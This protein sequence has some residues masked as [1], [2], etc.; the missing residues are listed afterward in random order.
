MSMTCISPREQRKSS[1]L[2]N[3]YNVFLMKA[4]VFASFLGVWLVESRHHVQRI[5]HLKIQRGAP[6]WWR[7]PARLGPRCRR[8]TR[9]LPRTSVFFQRF[10]Y[11]HQGN[12][13]A[14]RWQPTNP[15]NCSHF[16]KITTTTTSQFWRKSV[17]KKLVPRCW[18]WEKRAGCGRSAPRRDPRKPCRAPVFHS[19][20]WH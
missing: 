9:R 6:R 14:S 8:E 12:P 19:D 11:P 1:I 13:G 16:H 15:Q 20:F 5:L 18:R 10:R 3:Y 4:V 2:N 7:F 17:K